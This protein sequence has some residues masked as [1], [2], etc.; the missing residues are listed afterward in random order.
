MIDKIKN[1]F[2]IRNSQSYIEH[3]RSLGMKIGNNVRFFGNVKDIRIDET[4]PSLV[5]IGDNVMIVAPFCILTHGYEWFVFKNKY[6]KM[7]GSSG[8]VNIGNNIYFGRG[9]TITK[10]VTIGDNVVVGASSLVN[11]SLS[12][13]GVYA[14]IPC[15]KI[16][17]LDDFFKIRESKQLEEAKEYAISIKER[18]NRQ[19]RPED[20][21]EF[22]YLFLSRKDSSIKEFNN[23]IRKKLLMEKKPVITVESQLGEAYESFL[24]SKPIFSSFDEFLEHCGLKE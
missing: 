2:G 24:N 16:Y 4:R 19:P 23:N 13:D 10:G 1:A 21:R 20:F 18:F 15:K 11:K 14:G 7:L 8:K 22:F 3:L 9:V 6:K 17:D 5:T 12:D